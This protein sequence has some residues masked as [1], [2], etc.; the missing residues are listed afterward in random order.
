MANS[1]S[2]GSDRELTTEELLNAYGGI[3]EFTTTDDQ[4]LVWNVKEKTMAYNHINRPSQE[5]KISKI[6]RIDP[7]G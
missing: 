2:E 4:T 1:K 3:I 6:K 5:I 7:E